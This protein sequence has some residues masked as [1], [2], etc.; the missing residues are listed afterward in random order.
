V[1]GHDFTGRSAVVTGAASGMG[2]SIALGFAAAGARVT[3]GDI[4]AAGLAETV[5]LGHEL[6]AE[7]VAV[8][9]DVSQEEAVA[10]LVA[11]AVEG[12]GRIDHMVNNAGIHIEDTRI[13]ETPIEVYDRILAVNLRSVFLGT[14]FAVTEM[15]QQG[16]GGTVV[17]VA[18]VNS[19]KPQPIQAAYTASKHGIL[20]L[21]KSAAMEY[22]ADGIRINAV[23]PGAI[24]T[25]L[26]R[27]ALGHRDEQLIAQAQ[28]FFSLNGR[29]GR[30]EEVA[31]A[32]LWLSSDRSGYVIGHAL[33]VD[34][35]YLTK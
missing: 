20:G 35:G 4:D 24:D 23:L 8:A 15:L 6:G 31:E 25:P 7:I 21:T 9:T 17:N 2:R 13:H 1:S 19:V 3:V 34:G 12:H 22:A 26:L 27:G 16:D 32:V 33:A 10:G 11:R 29:F 5:R 18:S 14:R 28:S 30:P